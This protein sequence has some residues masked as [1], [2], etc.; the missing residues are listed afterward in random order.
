[1]TNDWFKVG[2]CVTSVGIGFLLGHRVGTLLWHDKSVDEE[3][4]WLV[5]SSSSIEMET[6]HLDHANDDDDDDD[7]LCNFEWR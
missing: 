1:M 2:M 5:D 4:N 6:L 7:S 3:R